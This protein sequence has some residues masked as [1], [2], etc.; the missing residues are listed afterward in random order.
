[1]GRVKTIKEREAKRIGKKDGKQAIHTLNE[2]KKGFRTKIR[3]IDLDKMAMTQNRI[4][5]K[6]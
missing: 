2:V 6:V 4:R 3:K 1:M 5:Q